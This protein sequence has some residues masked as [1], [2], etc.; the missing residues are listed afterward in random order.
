MSRSESI[1]TLEPLI[2]AVQEGL[3]S[4]GWSLSGLQ[5]TT[6]HEYEG[7]WAGDSSR[8]AYLFFHQPGELEHVSVDVFLDET[9]RGL[10]G[11]LALVFDTP[12]LGRG[13]HPRDLLDQLR[14]V[15]TEVLPEGYTVP[16]SVRARSRSER[17]PA[18]EADVEVRVKLVI[19]KAAIETG[20]DALAALAAATARSFEAF[21]R[22]PEV[23]RLMD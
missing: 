4:V 12:P 8:S 6:S 18:E 19:P 13:P 21:C 22:R 10:R 1:L 17:V 16:I 9:S 11:N 20:H 15:A 14:S 23:D 2:E 7:R 5:K 3:E